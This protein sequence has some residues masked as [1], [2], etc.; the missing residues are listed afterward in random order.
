MKTPFT[1][2]LATLGLCTGA[3]LAADDR[4]VKLELAT[5]DDDLR[6]GGEVSFVLRMIDGSEQK[7]L[8]THGE[9]FPDNTMTNYMVGPK[10]PRTW[11]DVKDFGIAARLHAGDGALL[12]PDKWKVY[13]ILRGVGGTCSG[14][15]PFGESCFGWRNA[16]FNFD[17]NGTQYSPL[18]SKL[19]PCSED[20]QCNGNAFCGT[21]VARCEP[22]NRGAD[23]L[24]CARLPA[25]TAACGTGYNC[26]EAQK[27]CVAIGCEDPDR[28]RDGENSIACGGADCDDSDPNRAPARTEICDADGRDED[29]DL[30]TV[31]NR[32][33]DR[34][35]FIDGR[36][37]N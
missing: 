19:G 36:C 11:A 2:L 4:P 5:Q 32:D 17:G 31:G 8:L 35:G 14:W 6:A 24:G 34:D 1:L 9:R 13:V 37:W 12:Q 33:V 30:T 21:R 20:T 16:R 7:T 3:A 22:R 18:N 25:P 15:I 28:D 27:R 23:R 29:C 10:P 26:N